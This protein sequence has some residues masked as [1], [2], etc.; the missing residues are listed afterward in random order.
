MTSQNKADG[1]SNNK[2]HS[3][4]LLR[5]CL[6][7]HFLT[8]LCYVTSDQKNF[9]FRTE[10]MLRRNIW[11]M[12]P[13]RYLLF[14]STLVFN[15]KCH[16]I[17]ITSLPVW[18][19]HFSHWSDG[20]AGEGHFRFRILIF[21]TEFISNRKY[22]TSCPEALFFSGN[23]ILREIHN[24]CFR[25]LILQREV[26]SYRKYLSSCSEILSFERKWYH[27]RNTSLPVWKSHFLNRKW[28]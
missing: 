28:R 17:R 19:S 2:K 5:Q 4:T 26:T 14:K 15:R 8:V 10:V 25:N 9:T 27:T 6:S 24:F 11:K 20:I 21:Q 12:L 16:H 1:L 13:W 23:D 7:E 3:I 22:V 18:E